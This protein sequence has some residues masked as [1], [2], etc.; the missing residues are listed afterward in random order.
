MPLTTSLKDRMKKARKKANSTFDDYISWAS[1]NRPDVIE[2]IQKGEAFESTEPYEAIID[3]NRVKSKVITNQPSMNGTLVP[4]DIIKKKFKEMN[5]DKDVIPMLLGHN[6]DMGV[7]GVWD[8]FTIEEEGKKVFGVMSGILDDT[9]FVTKDVIA[10]LKD[11]F[12]F[13]TSF[14]GIITDSEL[15][16]FKKEGI[17]T[18]VKDFEILE[19]SLTRNPANPD[20]PL[21]KESNIKDKIINKNNKTMTEEEKKALEA[22]EAKKAEEEKKAKEAKELKAK[23]DA[24]KKASEEKKAEEAKEAENKKTVKAKEDTKAIEATETIKAQESRI[25]ALEATIKVKEVSEKA[26]TILAG[27]GKGNVLP[28]FKSEVETILASENAEVINAFETI[29]KEGIIVNE[30]FEGSVGSSKTT[31]AEKTDS[32]IKKEAVEASVKNGTTVDV[33]MSKLYAEAERTELN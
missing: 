17:A 11:G 31:K 15:V 4:G 14:G 16:D 27:E 32:D 26:D 5:K 30:N 22:K 6:A 9:K 28:K 24:E 25:A 29:L 10:D 21:E 12:Q 18:R 19:T 3:E 2:S 7:L 33:E 13:G 20:S 1:K 23:E 8:T